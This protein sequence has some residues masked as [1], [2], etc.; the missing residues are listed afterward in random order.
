MPAQLLTYF[1]NTSNKMLKIFRSA[2]LDEN[3]ENA[4]KNF[5]L[6]KIQDLLKTG[7]NTTAK[8]A[9]EDREKLKLRKNTRR[10]KQFE[11]NKNFL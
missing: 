9:T 4:T 3:Q 1:F 8:T 10:L 2:K 7:F 6:Q 11:R 5:Y